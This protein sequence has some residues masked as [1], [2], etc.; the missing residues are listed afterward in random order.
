MFIFEAGWSLLL[1]TK[2]EA[3]FGPLSSLTPPPKEATIGITFTILLLA[4]AVPDIQAGRHLVATFKQVFCWMAKR[5][6]ELKEDLG[7]ILLHNNVEI[8]A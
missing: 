4:T 2:A 1:E 7:A 8:V 6:R 5:F 3:P